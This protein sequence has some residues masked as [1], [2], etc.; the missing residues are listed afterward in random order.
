MDTR[1]QLRFRLIFNGEWAEE[2]Y[3]VVYWMRW[4]Y[5]IKLVICLF[6]LH[7]EPPQSWKFDYGEFIEVVYTDGGVTY[8]PGEPDVYWYQSLAVGYGIFQRWWAFEYGDSS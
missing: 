8:I 3:N 2:D 4:F 6:I 5:R 7:R 1:Q